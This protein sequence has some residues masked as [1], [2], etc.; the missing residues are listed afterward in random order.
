MSEIIRRIELHICKH[1]NNEVNIFASPD[2]VGFR[3]GVQSAY[4]FKEYADG[5]TIDEA[6]KN[7]LEKAKEASKK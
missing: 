2:G 7:A 5:R 6:V 3:C 4:R 1:I